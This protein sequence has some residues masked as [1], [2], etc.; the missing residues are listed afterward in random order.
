MQPKAEYRG[1][2]LCGAVR[3][4][5]RPNEPHVDA[6]HC[7]MCRAW[8]GGPLLTLECEANVDFE[9]TEH[10][11]TFAS[12]DWAERGFCRACGTHLFY[13]LKSA[14]HYAVPVGLFAEVDAWKL[15]KQIFVDE[16]PAFYS[17]E[18][19]TEVLTG[20]EVFA[21]YAAQLS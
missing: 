6:C 21:A 13:R 1:A 7:R 8:G 11:S 14:G 18:Q 15:T 4:T 20:E 16:K 3:V 17:F 9:G 12:S 2:C 19:Q 10:I 5:A